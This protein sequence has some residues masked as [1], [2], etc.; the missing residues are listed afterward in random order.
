MAQLLNTTI[1]GT[2]NVNDYNDNTINYF[3]IDSNGNLTLKS[4]NNEILKVGNDGLNLTGNLTVKNGTA[5][6]STID[7]TDDNGVVNVQKP[8]SIT[9][10]LTASGLITANGGLNVKTGNFNSNV[11]L[12]VNDNIT[13]NSLNIKNG[14]SDILTVEN[15]NVKIDKPLTVN[16]DVSISPNSTGILVNKVFDSVMNF[17]EIIKNST[18]YVND[19]IENSDTKNTYLHIRSLKN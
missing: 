18:E 15:D 17:D 7:T 2:L 12:T 13:A 11:K 1:N 5:F 9:G 4:N 6:L 19:A 8:M 14:D 10:A 16:G 3:N